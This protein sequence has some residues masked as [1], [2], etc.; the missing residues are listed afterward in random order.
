V[1]TEVSAGLL[2]DEKGRY[3]LSRRKSGTHL[4]GSWEFPGGKIESGESPRHAL[5]RELAEEL[6]IVPEE[7]EPLLTLSHTYPE[8]TV[9]LYFR[10][11]R[12][13]RGTPRGLEGQAL[14][15]ASPEQMA[16]LV[17][18]R[19]DRPLICALNLH[20]VYAITPDPESLGGTGAFLDY[21]QTLLDAGARLIQL[22]AHSL[23]EQA[24]AGLAIE[25]GRRAR[26]HDV[27]WLLNGP[28]ELARQAGADGVHLASAALAEM[29]T[30]PL[31]DSMLVAASCH[32]RDELE[33]AGRLELDFV[34]LSPVNTTRSHPEAIPLGW[35]E[36]EALCAQSPLPVFGLGGM[37]PEDLDRARRVG[38]FGVAGI[39][40]F[41][42]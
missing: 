23:D 36:F 32:D 18:P 40:G 34:T 30:R 17:M 24:L 15:W 8:K 5:A 35:E 11:V 6:G 42:P 19:A 25:C 39:R 37:A 38:A 33:A 12:R 10:K 2:C 16:S 28:P 22:R 14:K 13:W 4:A 1:V 21:W 27:R 31:P 20:P 7:C 3:L 9:R 26:G 29:D 41:G